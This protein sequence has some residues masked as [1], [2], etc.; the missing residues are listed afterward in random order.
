MG[1]IVTT[2][3]ICCKSAREDVWSALADTHQLNRAIGNNPLE[4]EPVHQGAERYRIRTRLAGLSLEYEEEPFEWKQPEFLSIVRKFLNGPARRYQIEWRLAE[5]QQGGTSVQQRLEVEP[6]SA[7]FWPFVAINAMTI[8]NRLVREIVRVDANLAR[9]ME[10]YADASISL[11]SI[12]WPWN[13][14]GRPCKLHFA[15]PARIKR[16][17]K[18]KGPVWLRRMVWTIGST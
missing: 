6:R 4:S 8:T 1:A 10:A 14:P 2:R 7:W 15:W 18:I 17:A 5:N 13:A 16:W 12:P 9:D 3:E 11:R